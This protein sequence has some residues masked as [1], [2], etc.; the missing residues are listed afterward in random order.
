[1]SAP[2]LPGTE[3]YEGSPTTEERMRVLFATLLQVNPALV[4]D[5][6]RPATLD[7]WDSMQHLILVAGFEEEFGIDIDPEEAVDMYESFATFAR[8][9]RGKLEQ[10]R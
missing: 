7:R 4:D 1:M 9:A 6:T 5:Q 2:V 10:R 8:I 3:S